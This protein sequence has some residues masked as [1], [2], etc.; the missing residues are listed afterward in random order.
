MKKVDYIIVG[1]GYAGL[2]FA[3]RLMQNKKSFVLFSDGKK[4]ASRVSAGM[5]NPVVLKKFTTFWQA[6]NQIDFLHTSLNDFKQFSDVNVFINKPVHRIFH[7]ED[8]KTLW[9]KKRINEELQPFLDDE[10]PTI[11]GVTNDYGTGRV[12]QSGRVDVA[13]FFKAFFDVL[14]KRGELVE[15][16]FDYKSLK[17]SVYKDFEFKHIVFCEGIGVKD[18]PYFKSIE[19]NPNKGHQLY[20]RLNKE[21]ETD[22]TLK[23]KHF[24][25]RLDKDVFFY[26]GT[27]DRDSVGDTIDE[28]AVEQLKSGLNEFYKDGFDVQGVHFGFRPTVKDRRPILGRH[29]SNKNYYVFNGLGAR[30]VLNGCFFSQT[31]FDFIENDIPL[32]VEVDINRFI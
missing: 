19:I 12:K 29:E 4:G 24:L 21:L 6:Q 17:G 18:N 7:N 10:F 23:K 26:G 27:Y 31:L 5:V 32:P 3:L 14:E 20:V 1:G 16:V 15:E 25:F 11:A 22:I 30:G 8:E 9:T 2:F 13:A 28:S